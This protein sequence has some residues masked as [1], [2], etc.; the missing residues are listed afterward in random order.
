MALSFEHSVANLFTFPAAL[1]VCA[2]EPAF[3]AGSGLNLSGL[4]WSHALLS[5]LV[6]VLLGNVRGRLMALLAE[7]K[8]GRS[9]WA[10]TAE[11][12][13][14]ST[15]PE[16]WGAR[17]GMKDPSSTDIVVHRGTALTSFYMCG[18]LYRMDPVTGD[19]LGKETFGGRF[20]AEG[21]SAHTKVDEHTGELI[22]FNYGKT[23]P[24]LHFGVVDRH[25]ALVHYSPVPLPGP[26]L[27]HDLQIGLGTQDH[28]HP[29]ADQGPII[30]D[31]SSDAQ[32]EPPR[33]G[34][35]STVSG[36]TSQ[37]MTTSMGA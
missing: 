24:Y 20:P 14:L 27:P 19:N 16:S 3:A 28:H 9:L 11:S 12:P 31:D 18:D 37:A 25:G 13:S 1:G 26:R 17:G 10:G 33:G 34:S 22:F 7:Q 32:R 4:T 35:P 5:N 15:R 21:V 30:G 8:A 29:S 36:G 6:P 2:L 23:A